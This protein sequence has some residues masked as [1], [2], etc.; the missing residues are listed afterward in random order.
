MSS[1]KGKA[2]FW[3]AASLAMAANVWAENPNTT[4]PAIM[5]SA[6]VVEQ[7]RLHNQARKDGLKQYKEVRHY[8]VEY[9]GLTT[10]VGQM[11]VEVNFDTSTGKTLRVV[12]QSGS[13][14]LCDRVLKRLVESEQ[15]AGKDK[16]STALT[17][18][19][20]RFESA[21]SE[22][23]AG[24]PAYVLNV[25]PL[26]ANK[27]LYVGKIWVDAADFAVAKIEA[28]PAKSPS[29]WIKRTLIHHTYGHTGGFWLPRLNRSETKVRL[30]GTAVLTIDYGTYEIVPH[31]AA[32]AA[33]LGS[34]R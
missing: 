16:S 34:G 14:L 24:R 11:E 27:F 25:E 26:V 19:N 30:G 20:Y 23:V 3:A 21:G 13:K 22:N 4:T 1:S 12:S 32:D 2:L 15:E 29:F 31:T 6:Q 10:L 17:S 8:R 7:M 33:S 18:A 28:E 9:H 5:S